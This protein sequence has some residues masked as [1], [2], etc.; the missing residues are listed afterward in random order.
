MVSAVVSN[1]LDRWTVC[2]SLYVLNRRSKLPVLVFQT[3]KS[4]TRLRPALSS[5]NSADARPQ[6]SRVLQPAFCKASARGSSR[7]HSARAS[8]GFCSLV[9]AM[10]RCS[11]SVQLMQPLGDGKR[12]AVNMA[13]QELSAL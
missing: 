5:G 12:N 11:L 6:A 7:R 3:K 9:S 4:S 1:K 2:T 13:S 8:L 10:M